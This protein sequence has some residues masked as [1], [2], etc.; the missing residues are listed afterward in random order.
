MPNHKYIGNQIFQCID[1]LDDNCGAFG[2]INR[3]IDN[4]IQ[5]SGIGYI[6]SES[7]CVGGNTHGDF[8][9]PTKD[10]NQLG[11]RYTTNKFEKGNFIKHIYTA[12]VSTNIVNMILE[13]DIYMEHPHFVTIDICEVKH[14][15]YLSGN[16]ETVNIPSLHYEDLSLQTGNTKGN[17]NFPITFPQTTTLT[18]RFKFLD[19]NGNG[20]DQVTMACILYGTV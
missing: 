9:Y 8:Y 20:N 13:Y 10:N 14:D 15:T 7:F 3:R 17:F 4:L 16:K 2:R 5:V 1:V 11:V 18:V 6:L 12:T 19:Q